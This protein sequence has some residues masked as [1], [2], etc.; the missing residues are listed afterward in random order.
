MLES[1]TIGADAVEKMQV[2]RDDRLTNIF[3][4]QRELSAEKNEL[5]S[6]VRGLSQIR[7]EIE[8][9][10][11]TLSL[12]E[13]ARK[14]FASFEDICVNQTC[15]LFVRSSSSYGKNLLYLKDQ[16]KDLEAVSEASSRRI[17]EIRLGEAALAETANLIKNGMAQ[18]P[19]Q[20]PVDHLVAAASELTERLIALKS[21]RARE[22]EAQRIERE[23]VEKLDQRNREQAKLA[24]IERAGG[25]TDVEA[26]R[27]RTR[28]SE[29]VQYWLGVLNTSNVGMEVAVDPDFTVTFNGQKLSK[30]NGSTRTRL[31]LSIRTATVELLTSDRSNVPQFFVLDAPRQHDIERA[32]FANYI[33]ELKQLAIR[34]KL[35]IIF[36]SSNFRYDL[37]KG[38]VE[39]KPTFPGEKHDMFLGAHQHS[40]AAEGS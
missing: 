23:Y 25:G 11:N 32:D 30:F 15:G 34:N 24:D 37:G 36:S 6:R 1:L 33:A 19:R 8:I 13:E 3:R 31:V 20:T 22:L 18:G 14:I 16:I 7:Q 28:I 38:D 4:Q 35:Q 12:N 2:D 17:E 26:L 27:L 39:W 29:R 5:E 9:E 21:S 40:I 10:S